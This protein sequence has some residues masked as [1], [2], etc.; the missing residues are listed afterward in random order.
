MV[1]NTIKI[2]TIT[3]NGIVKKKNKISRNIPVVSVAA[4]FPTRNIVGRI[5]PTTH[6]AINCLFVRLVLSQLS[7]VVSIFCRLLPRFA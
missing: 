4:P 3:K 5:A 7:E 2:K 1:L 6:E